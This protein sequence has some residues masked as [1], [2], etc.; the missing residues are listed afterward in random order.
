MKLLIKALLMINFNGCYLV[1]LKLNI[2]YILII[3]MI[4]IN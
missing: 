4:K 3:N 2:S 1:I